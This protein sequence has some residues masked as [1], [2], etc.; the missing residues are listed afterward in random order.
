MTLKLPHYSRT[1]PA[2]LVTFS[3]ILLQTTIFGFILIITLLN[4]VTQLSPE[5]TEFSELTLAVLMSPKDNNTH[6]SYLNYLR[7]HVDLKANQVY[8]NHTSINLLSQNIL[9]I[10]STNPQNQK[11][12]NYW[13]N[14][15]AT[16]PYYRDGYLNLGKILL[17]EG[18][19]QEGSSLINKGLAL[20]PLYNSLNSF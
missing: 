1:I 10:S 16:Y 4:I 19:Y 11:K 15:V 7:D 3:L 20:D 2:Q 9:G 14:V 13:K 5:N 6:K 18:K 12:I 17:E 8:S